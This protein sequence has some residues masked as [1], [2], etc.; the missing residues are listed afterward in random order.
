M[1]L[2]LSQCYFLLASNW[3]LTGWKCHIYNQTLKDLWKLVV[4]FLV[5]KWSFWAQDA[6]ILTWKYLTSSCRKIGA[7]YYRPT[8]HGKLANFEPRSTFS[9]QPNGQLKILTR[10]AK[11]KLRVHCTGTTVN[12]I[13]Q[14]MQRRSFSAFCFRCLLLWVERPETSKSNLSCRT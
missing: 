4:E 10:S 9:L 12:V 5:K 8:K 7:L 14:Q 3:K 11:I 6:I 2:I 1:K 13:A